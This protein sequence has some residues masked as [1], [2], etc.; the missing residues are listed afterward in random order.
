MIKKIK[1]LFKGHKFYMQYDFRMGL[2]SPHSLDKCVCC[3]IERYKTENNIKE[4][5]CKK[6]I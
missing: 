1:C 5:K 4:L 3:K 2:Y 6:K